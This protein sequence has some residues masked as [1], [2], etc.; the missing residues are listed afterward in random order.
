MISPRLAIYAIAALALIGGIWYVK[1]LHATAARVPVL[2]RQVAQERANMAAL[3]AARA[4]ELKIAKDASDG[5]QKELQRLELE[6]SNT[7][8]VRL[9]KP[10][11]NPAVSASAGTASG[12][13]AA[14][15]G[16][17]P[18]P[19]AGDSEPGPDIGAALIEYG[20]ACEANGLQL[21]RLQ[22]WV[23]SR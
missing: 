19:I 1:R 9:C 11:R 2:E 13:N 18:Q 17:E 20:L 12:P 7:P 14:E 15:A 23:K 10:V 16:R 6:R 3:Q 5:Y 21:D 8:V 22:E 4:H